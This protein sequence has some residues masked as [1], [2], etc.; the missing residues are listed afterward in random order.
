[1]IR[2]RGY[3][4]LLMV[5]AATA[6]VG[7]P[8]AHAQAAGDAIVVGGSDLTGFPTVSLTVSV[9][10]A[11]TPAVAA[12]VTVTEAGARR[13]VTVEPL[14]SDDLQVVLAI[15]TSG[16]MTGAPLDAAKDAATQFL[17]KVPERTPVAVV[18][19]GEKSFV[20]SAFTADK[21]D[22]RQ[23]IAGLRPR[24]ETTLFD[25]VVMS[26]NLFPTESNARRVIIV[27]TDGADTR[28]TQ[29]LRGAIDAV[30]KSKA[31]VYSVALQTKET[32]YA[33][34]QAL[35][36]VS[37]GL[38][39]NAEDPRALG[40][41][42]AR[43]SSAVN[44]RYRLTWKA[45]A[46]GL[47]A[48]TIRFDP[49]GVTALQRDIELA[50]PVVQPKTEN[51]PAA[52][53]APVVTVPVVHVVEPSS[54]ARGSVLLVV[55]LI[56]MF[57]ALVVLGQMIVLPRVQV[58]RLSREFGVESKTQLS[59]FSQRAVTAVDRAITR[60]NRRL[61]LES[62]LQQAGSSVAPGEALSAV[63]AVA[64]VAFLGV[65]MMRGVVFGLAAAVLVLA[66]AAMAL[67]VRIDMRA[68]RFANQ[69]DATLQLMVSSLRTGYGVAQAV[70]AVATEAPAPTGDEFR[71]AARET[72]IGRDLPSAL[73]DVAL[74]TKNEDFGWVVDAIEINREVGGS[75]AEVLDNASVTLRDRMRLHRQVRALSA[76][77]RMS[78]VVLV[79]LPLLLFFY[80]RVS[81]PDYL[82]PLFHSSLGQQLLA[83]G[84]GLILV[85]GLWLRRI[86][87]VKY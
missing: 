81:N 59:A 8:A 3:V 79:A 4:L 14:A 32:D 39:A 31:V 40:E 25:A 57:V 64:V 61:T 2:R 21:I 16:S 12:N 69:L 29:D 77:G 53:V 47:T 1:M 80:L 18:G 73:R 62:L 44:N 15:D 78:G 74:R 26:A 76:E 11:V 41:T 52:V 35:S 10:G 33:A 51:A 84:V 49:P 70:D 82:E 50:Y 58:R 30:E 37:Q 27:L 24:G 46:S 56:A 20:Q 71:R 13:D 19:F 72:R 87:Q 9:P 5:A 68:R 23:A 66:A 55:G 85:G 63:L 60:S 75:L 43:V 83:M 45:S 38:V 65:L 6:F 86:V 54:L 36:S 67:R 48:T 28:S 17:A 22:S 42:F 7:A 34:L